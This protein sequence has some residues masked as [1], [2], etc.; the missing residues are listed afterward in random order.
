MALSM[1]NGSAPIQN[2]SLGMQDFMRILMTQLTYQ[3]PMKPMD[4]QQFMAQMAQF[5]SLQQSQEMNSKI[6]QLLNVQAFFNS[7]GLMGKTVEFTLNGSSSNGTVTGVSL[8]GSSPVF[9]VVSSGS[10]SVQNVNLSQIT[11]VRS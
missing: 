10:S 6:D 3:D 7:V 5:A 9:S 11:K 1:V 8:S 2:Q 4:N